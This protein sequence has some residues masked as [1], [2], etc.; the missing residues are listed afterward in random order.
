MRHSSFRS[1]RWSTILAGGV[2]TAFGCA[3]DD[4]LLF[5]NA[6]NAPEPVSEG[7]EVEL[8]ET[9]VRIDVFPA[10]AS[11]GPSL[12]DGFRALPKS[13][14][15]DLDGTDDVTVE[16]VELDAPIRFTGRVEGFQLNPQVASL[17]GRVVPVPAEV[18]LQLPGSVQNYVA[19]TN[20]GGDFSAWVG[21]RTVYTLSVH[22]LLPDFPSFS[23]NF[24]IADAARDI[25]LTLPFAEPLYGRVQSPTG[26][27]A[28]ASVFAINERGEPSATAIT[29]AEGWYTLR[30]GQGQFDVVCDGGGPGRLRPLLTERDVAVGELGALVDFDYVDQD[31]VLV[32]GRIVSDTGLPLQDVEVRFTATT[33]LN[34]GED[35]AWTFTAR[36]QEGNSFLAELIPGVYDIEVIPPPV[37]AQ[38]ALD[39]FAAAAAQALSPVRRELE[40]LLDDAQL[41][42][43][44]LPGTEFVVGSVTDD[45]GLA[46]E[47]VVVECTE[48]GFAERRWSARTSVT[49]NF[50]MELPVV[51]V[52]CRAVPPATE[53][54]APR[55]VT[56]TAGQGKPPVIVLDDGLVIRGTVVGPTGTPESLALVTVRRVDDD[57]ALATATTREDGTYEVRVGVQ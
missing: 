53:A 38:A 37:D 43:I 3:G 1:L 48:L 22:P 50:E 46:V 16:P 35:S 14:S 27:V 11:L 21:P 51:P 12:D 26:P 54:L 10:D 13:R 24:A 45:E 55:S 2:L 32:R 23:D 47:G 57:T 40:G 29:D 17:P 20:D 41:G 49:G 18:R 56:F 44:A 4:G 6:P 52:T 30:V 34:Y 39:G 9:T 19:S 42:E 25:E 33:L 8:T 31:P 28:G 15:I 7:D 36:L 5:D